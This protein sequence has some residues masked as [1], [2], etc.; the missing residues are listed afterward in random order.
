MNPESTQAYLYSIAPPF[1]ARWSGDKCAWSGIPIHK[2]DHARYLAS[3]YDPVKNLYSDK[4]MVLERFV[5]LAC[6]HWGIWTFARFFPPIILDDYPD[7]IEIVMRDATTREYTRGS[8]RTWHKN[9]S[10]AK[11]KEHNLKRA[12]SSCVAYRCTPNKAERQS[13][14]VANG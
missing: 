5:N 4:T 2:G 10:W 7:K 1:K 9:G 12:L 3:G 6:M 13:Q 11:T 14:E 8:D